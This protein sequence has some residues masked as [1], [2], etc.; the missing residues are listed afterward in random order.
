[1]EGGLSADKNV[2]MPSPPDQF[3]V[4]RLMGIKI[5]L[6]DKHY[7]PYLPSLSVILISRNW[8]KK[9][10]LLYVF[11]PLYSSSFSTLSPPT[12]GFASSSSS[13]VNS[14]SSVWTS[15]PL[16]PIGNT[17]HTVTSAALVF[18][19]ISG[20]F[21]ATARVIRYPVPSGTDIPLNVTTWCW[22][23]EYGKNIQIGVPLPNSNI[24]KLIPTPTPSFMNT[25]TEGMSIAARSMCLGKNTTNTNNDTHQDVLNDDG[26][27]NDVINKNL[28]AS[29][30]SPSHSSSQPQSNLQHRNTNPER[31][32]ISDRTNAEGMKIPVLHALLL[33]NALESYG[34]TIVTN[35][36][37]NVSTPLR[38]SVSSVNIHENISSSNSSSSSGNP[39]LSPNRSSSHRLQG[40]SAS[41]AFYSDTVANHPEHI[42]NDSSS[43]SSSSS[44]S[45]HDNCFSEFIA[46]AGEI[47]YV[48]GLLASI[49]NH[50]MENTPHQSSSHFTALVQMLTVLPTFRSS[51]FRGKL[52]TKLIGIENSTAHALLEDIGR[53]PLE[54]IA[55]VGSRV[56]REEPL[57]N[58][59][60][61][62]SSVY[63][64]Q[65][66]YGRSD[67][68]NDF[69][70]Y[71]CSSATDSECSSVSSSR[72]NSVTDVTSTE[73]D[74]EDDSFT[75]DTSDNESTS[76]NNQKLSS[77]LTNL[78]ASTSSTR[79]H[80]RTRKRLKIKYI[81]GDIDDVG[82]IGNG[83]G[84]S[85]PLRSL[86]NQRSRITTNNATSKQPT[87]ILDFS[88]DE[89]ENGQA[90][91]TTEGSVAFPS[92]SR[93]LKRLATPVPH[94]IHDF[95][96]PSNSSVLS[97][98]LSAS[99]ETK[100]LDPHVI[101]T[102]TPLLHSSI[103][104]TNM[105]LSP[106]VS[107]LSPQ[108]F[109]GPTMTVRQR[110]LL[111]LAR[112]ASGNHWETGD[113]VQPLVLDIFLNALQHLSPAYIHG[114]LIMHVL[115]ALCC[116]SP[117]SLVRVYYSR[118][119]RVLF[120]K[121]VPTASRVTL[122]RGTGSSRRKVPNLA[123]SVV[124]SVHDII[125]THIADSSVAQQR[126]RI[127][128]LPPISPSNAYRMNLPELAMATASTPATA[129][130]KHRGVSPSAVPLN[131]RW[132]EE[133][134]ERNPF[135][136]RSN[137][138]TSFNLE[139]S[140][141][142]RKGIVG[143]INGGPPHTGFHYSNTNDFAIEPL[144]LPNGKGLTQ[145]SF[146][147]LDPS[148]IRRLETSRGDT[149]F[150]LQVLMALIGDLLHESKA[151]NASR[152]NR[153][154]V[155]LSLGKSSK[156][157]S[158]SPSSGSAEDDTRNAL[159]RAVASGADLT[160]ITPTGLATTKDASGCD[161]VLSC[162]GCGGNC[163][164]RKSTLT[165]AAAEDESEERT[166]GESLRGTVLSPN[167]NTPELLNI[168]NTAPHS[169][170]QSTNTI[171]IGSPDAFDV[172]SPHGSV[173]YKKHADT[174]AAQSSQYSGQIGE[175]TVS[176]TMS[177][178][179][180][181]SSLT[182]PPHVQFP[183]RKDTP[184]IPHTFSDVSTDPDP[185][186]VRLSS[187][188]G[189]RSG[190]GS[191]GS[192]AASTIRAMCPSADDGR[193]AGLG[194]WID[195]SRAVATA[196]IKLSS[197][198]DGDDGITAAYKGV[199]S[200]ALQ[201]CHA[202]PLLREV[203]LRRILRKW[204]TG[205]S[206]N[207]VALLEFLAT[208]LSHVTHRGD[209][210]MTE[211]REVLLI[212]ICKCLTSLH[213]KVARN[214]LVLIDPT[215]HLID[216]LVDDTDSLKLLL[217][218]LTTNAEH[219]WNPLVRKASAAA[220]A[221]YSGHFDPNNLLNLHPGID[222][223]VILSSPL[224]VR[225]GTV[226]NNTSFNTVNSNPVSP[227]PSNERS[228]G[229]AAVPEPLSV[230]PPIVSRRPSLQKSRVPVTM[231]S[232][233]EYSLATVARVGIAYD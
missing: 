170:G 25:I 19:Y 40:L 108:V 142:H 54:I 154:N 67:S 207:E 187:P 79:Q 233:D 98:H 3:Y 95:S 90:K 131:V 215:R 87:H 27:T 36:S 42:N 225:S 218:T 101:S 57:P 26:F 21:E 85:S 11:F 197:V 10:G 137:S 169:V 226:D 2:I 58:G 93:S 189:L 186:V 143:G 17:S 69:D 148:D 205:I 77:L 112:W 180:S 37:S 35:S 190:F 194:L 65:A 125:T 116:S 195:V 151:A 188:F 16:I 152:K 156:T 126:S 56:C 47:A 158:I 44:S 210:S 161:S 179:Q 198:P 227:G 92:P 45:I 159:S 216:L 232:D 88:D 208:L 174:S 185:K 164:L 73:S 231:N 228:S 81:L 12:S 91:I 1:M 229:S 204:P 184:T 134:A 209:L 214:A 212:R 75:V 61:N 127:Q 120:G 220:A 64:S 165:H 153:E 150:D 49:I 144:L 8:Y 71:R 22:L 219:H 129:S 223:N 132:P 119:L 23:G 135:L 221:V 176:G 171:G 6:M 183:S 199:L 99:E 123:R 78:N 29:P 115:Q 86:P 109:F 130:S 160:G 13:S 30:P 7:S 206:E 84:S 14:P 68:T 4:L 32:Y 196:A 110:V 202:C 105:V 114:Q 118:A 121:G 182:P 111:T 51:S 48:V 230:V 224:V 168:L 102:P 136:Y 70:G 141:N 24:H 89:G 193:G 128:E 28:L 9:N 5:P 18:P 201:L 74:Y 222:T 175:N 82:D 63:S 122:H 181:A 113:A 62:S 138:T 192:N 52:L 55:S 103:G 217:L 117:S 149:E 139:A 162:S 200:C 38:S 106:S 107:L 133:K 46:N 163:T 50:T 191:N 147:S 43:S 100:A 124:V 83:S 72:R 157:S 146:P 34:S 80:K 97:N 177:I 20:T 155:K 53:L 96:V 41:S 178:S 94:G 203:V 166:R 66:I 140:P 167:V 33:D 39:L 145:S 76:S 31:S 104:A 172:R 59:A 60:D 173:P 211:L 213:I 15:L